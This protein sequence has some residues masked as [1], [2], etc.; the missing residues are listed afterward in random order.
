M[1]GSLLTIALLL[2]PA[3]SGL[4]VRT[5]RFFRADPGQA[6]GVTQVTA[7]LRI[8]A[9]LPTAGPGGE[10]S[11]G[12]RVRVVGDAGVLYDQAWR[13]RTG[14]PFPRGDADRLD[15]LRFT[16]GSGAY[17]LEATV[18][19][20]VSGRR[21]SAV[22][23]I[24]AYGTPPAA[25]DLLLSSWLRPVSPADTVPQPGEFRRGGLILAI[26]PDVAVGGKRGS[27]AYLIETYSGTAIDGS[28]TITIADSLGEV[29]RRTDPTPVRVTAGIG[30]LTGLV[31][32]GEL[33]AGRFRLVASLT[34]AGRTVVR[35]AGFAVDPAAAVAAASLSDAAY[36]A[37][38]FG[39]DLDRAFAP[40]ATIAEADELAGWPARGTDL[41]KRRFLAGFW[42]RRDP[43][44]STGNER[45]ARF[46]DGVIYASA[47]YADSARGLEGW[48]TDRGRVFLREGLPT[49][50]VR[51][52]ARGRIPAYEV[53][54]YFERAG[55]YYV[56][57][58]RGPR[59][60]VAL[61]RTNDPRERG[62]RRWQQIL[63]PAG[64][65]ELVGLLGREV[66]E[67][68]P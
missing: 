4:L 53:W 9:D 65:Q 1:S 40:L 32:V 59:G 16:L 5:V 13:K 60:G 46:Y 15:V 50:T 25:S 24:E 2:Q 33:E 36:F 21:A 63:T 12:F 30:L 34:M 7:M 6:P 58:D 26:A 31:E 17:R 3:D 42:E 56:F 10:V 43:T 64:V 23:P 18:E 57:A 19:D 35:E 11:L 52:Q 68:R 38:I 55:R 51:R 27:L 37:G 14:L 44:P 20:S 62:D 48:Q 67:E 66:L 49:Q 22:V 28:L 8:P 45:R 47:F 54:R 61:V 29:R 41:A 39:E